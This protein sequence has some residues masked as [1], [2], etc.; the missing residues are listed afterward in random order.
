M[1]FIDAVVT[2]GFDIG[3]RIYNLTDIEQMATL[4]LVGEGKKTEVVR[5]VPKHDSVTF[6]LSAV[7]SGNKIIAAMTL[8]GN[9]EG[10][11]RFGQRVDGQL[12]FSP[13]VEIPKVA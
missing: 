12:V 11:A 6:L 10:I 7:V 2:D 1:K 5:K 8:G 9:V 3:V 4:F 13:E